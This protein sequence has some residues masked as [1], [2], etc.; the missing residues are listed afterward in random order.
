[1]NAT[2]FEDTMAELKGNED[3]LTIFFSIVA[4]NPEVWVNV[5]AQLSSS[6]FERL[7][8]CPDLVATEDT[9]LKVLLDW[10]R[11]QTLD[12]CFYKTGILKHS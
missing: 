7:L 12:H 2:S 5:S 8:T 11:M 6:D 1:M 10:S 3:A 4:R 9:I